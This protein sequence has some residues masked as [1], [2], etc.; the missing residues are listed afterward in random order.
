[1]WSIYSVASGVPVVA[2]AELSQGHALSCLSVF[3]QNPIVGNAD[4]LDI[5]VHRFV[6]VNMFTAKADTGVIVDLGL[7]NGV[8]RLSN[9]VELMEAA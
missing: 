7:P 6:E 3:S 2:N 4:G 1:M 8:T 9:I 5:S